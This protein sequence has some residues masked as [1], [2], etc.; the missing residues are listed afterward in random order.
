M[1]AAVRLTARIERRLKK[2]ER[3][4]TRPIPRLTGFRRAEITTVDFKPAEEWRPF[5]PDIATNDNLGHLRD[6][7]PVSRNAPSVPPVDKEIRS[8]APS[9]IVEP[10][11]KSKTPAQTPAPKPK[12]KRT[13]TPDRGVAIKLLALG[14]VAFLATFTLVFKAALHFV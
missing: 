13:N 4:L 11:S 14:V 6:V 1:L 8:A 7:R 2:F 3:E 9:V 5:K 10:R 12:A